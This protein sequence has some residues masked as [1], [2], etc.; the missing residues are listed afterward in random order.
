MSAT[1][2]LVTHPHERCPRHRRCGWLASLHALCCSLRRLTS[3][4]QTLCQRPCQ[5]AMRSQGTPCPPSQGWA[6]LLAYGA[7]QRPHRP[8]MAAYSS[9]PSDLPTRRSRVTS[10][11]LGPSTMS[12]TARDTPAASIKTAQQ[13]SQPR[14]PL[15]PTASL[16]P[17][18]A[19]QALAMTASSSISLTEPRARTCT[20]STARQHPFHRRRRPTRCSLDPP[21]APQTCLHFRMAPLRAA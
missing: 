6:T 1:A 21:T 19:Y 17:A 5:A 7:L 20:S 3:C 8:W 12:S 18:V 13:R 9:Q 10:L 2:T 14:T 4:R 11:R 16:S 15:H